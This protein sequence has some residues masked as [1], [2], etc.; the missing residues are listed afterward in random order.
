MISVCKGGAQ[1]DKCI[2]S[3]IQVSMNA[4]SSLPL[5]CVMASGDTLHNLSC[6]SVSPVNQEKKGIVRQKHVH[7]AMLPQSQ[8][9]DCYQ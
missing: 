3:Q 8:K 1:E 5:Y 4:G 6:C 7:T 2:Y 9:N